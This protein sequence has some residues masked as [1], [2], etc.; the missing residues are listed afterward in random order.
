MSNQPSFICPTVLIQ[1]RFKIMLIQRPWTGK[2]SNF[3]DFGHF[4]NTFFE[5]KYWK[6]I[7]EKHFEKKYL[8]KNLFK[9]LILTP[10]P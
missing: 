4:E 1:V 5:K 9:K 8:K 3:L 2:M 6:N 7:L 10:P